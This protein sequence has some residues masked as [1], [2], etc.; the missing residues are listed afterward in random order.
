MERYCYPCRAVERAMRIREGHFC[1]QGFTR[2][3][4]R[5]PG[6]PRG[7]PRAATFAGSWAQGPPQFVSCR[8]GPTVRFA[9][10]SLLGNRS[11]GHDQCV[12]LSKKM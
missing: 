2:G 12:Y 9:W 3:S 7:S 10:K 11:L 5:F 6:V 8:Q 1:G 4:P